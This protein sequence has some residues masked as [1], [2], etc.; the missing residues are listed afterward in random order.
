MSMRTFNIDG[1]IGTFPGMRKK[2]FRISDPLPR[3][4]GRLR[5]NCGIGVRRLLWRLSDI[6]QAAE[7]SRLLTGTQREEKAVTKV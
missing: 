7:A 1:E 5:L 2:V 3:P 6:L 4:A